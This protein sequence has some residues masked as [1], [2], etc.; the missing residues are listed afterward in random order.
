MAK[1]ES[2]VDRVYDH[3]RRMAEQ[4][5]F[6]PD[7][8]INEVALASKLSSSRT[9][10]REA[11]NRLAAEGFLTFKSGRGFFCRSLS[12]AQ[13]LDLYEARIAIECEAMRLA[14]R[15]SSDTELERVVEK[16]AAF[17]PEY[18]D[19]SDPVRLLE[20]DE[21]FH[22]EVAKLSKNNELVRIL[23]NINGRIRFVRL[24]DL[25]T[26]RVDTRSERDDNRLSAHKVILSAL[27]GRDEG[28]AIEAMRKHIE[29]RR[30][31]A[32]EIV[33]KAFSQLY[34]EQT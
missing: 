5:E 9:P 27:A 33:R 22:V 2:N 20:I 8:R 18:E 12:P 1:S 4:F 15:R 7:S 29:R 28:A 26:L 25:K 30:E 24:I 21:Y 16:L 32:T 31:E 17:E 13:V 3:I 23:E 14:T 19:C 10:V 34:V 11:L 6:K